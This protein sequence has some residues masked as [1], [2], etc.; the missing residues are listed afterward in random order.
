MPCPWF[1]PTRPLEDGRWAV[2]PRVPLIEPWEGECRAG[3]Q[4]DVP[5]GEMLCTHC[6]S[7][8]A[9]GVCSR[10]T[11]GRG[12]AIRFH[13]QSCE[14]GALRLLYS[15]ERDCWPAGHGIIDYDRLERR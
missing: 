1:C 2:P 13:M 15:Y 9:R 11:E 5:H 3:A 10:F 6:N 14:P 12:D 7:G 4:P 8:Y